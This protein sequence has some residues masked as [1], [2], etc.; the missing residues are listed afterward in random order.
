MDTSTKIRAFSCRQ[1]PDER[2]ALLLALDEAGRRRDDA[3]KAFDRISDPALIT[4]A[5]H[6]L[7]AAAAEYGA[8]LREAKQLGIRRTFAEAEAMKKE[9]SAPGKDL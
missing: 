6:R 7:E 2:L 9:R 5:V 1:P 4:S 3:L 8:L